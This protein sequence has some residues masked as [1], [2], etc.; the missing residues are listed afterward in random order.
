[1][2]RTQT[3]IEQSEEFSD[4]QELV[5]ALREIAGDEAL[6]QT[7]VYYLKETATHVEALHSAYLEAIRALKS[8]QRPKA[9]V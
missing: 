3:L 6:S 5:D 7:T 8:L 4:S 9:A 2:I 1:M